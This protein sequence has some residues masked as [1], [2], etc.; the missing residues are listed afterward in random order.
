MSADRRKNVH[1]RSE[2]KKESVFFSFLLRNLPRTPGVCSAKQNLA[3]NFRLTLRRLVTLVSPIFFF[4]LGDQVGVLYDCWGF[5]CFHYI[6]VKKCDKLVTPHN[7]R[8]T[9]NCNRIHQSQCTFECNEGFELR[10]SSTRQ[11]ILNKTLNILEW[12][13]IPAQC[14]GKLSGKLND[15]SISNEYFCFCL[16]VC[17]IITFGL[18]KRES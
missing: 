2:R 3:L 1:K 5:S 6:T 15:I 7:G 12:S 13:G 14:I 4:T 11:C 8:I 16:F 18:E 9:G 10:G 17:F